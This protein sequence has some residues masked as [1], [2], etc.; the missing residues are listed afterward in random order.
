MAEAT[1]TPGTSLGIS[2]EEF[3]KQDHSEFLSDPVIPKTDEKPE[4]K[5]IESS[6]QTDEDDKEASSDK[7]DSEAQEHTETTADKEEVADTN[8]DTQQTDETSEDSDD[9]ESLDT[10]K[11]DSTDTKGDTQDTKEFD[12]KSAFEKVT[13]PF[14]ANGTKMQ[15]KNPEDIQRLMQMGANYQKKMA[16]LKPHLKTI[17]M[18]EN[19]DLLDEAKL[20]QLIDIHKKDPKAIAKLIEESG[21]DPLDINTDDQS[22][23][24]PKDYSVSDKEYNLDQVLEEIKD[25]ETFS[26]TIDVLTK[27]WDQK[28]KNVISD[29]PNFIT[30]INQHMGNGVFDKV[31]SVMQQDKALGKLRGVSDA[32][33]YGQILE[34]MHKKGILKHTDDDKSSSEKVSS[35][36]E[37]K[38]QANAER[39]KKRKAAALG[40]QSTSKKEAAVKNFLNLSDEDFLKQ[41]APG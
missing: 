5:E 10:G 22:E 18:L 27:E 13:S 14:K 1:E 40:K 21:I 20:H 16:S 35:E 9:S 41:N 30:I 17:K 34:D 19:N 39:D 2:D 31:N 37:D 24:K 3:L 33:A 26:R 12:Y 23:Y 25:T 29:N 8:E 28:S 6:D 15:V 11:K 4:D 7:E 38:S 32:D 36:S